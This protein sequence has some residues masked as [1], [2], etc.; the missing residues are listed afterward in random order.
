MKNIFKLLLVGLVFASCD[1]VEPTIYN[2]SSENNTFL[3]FSRTAY[4]LPVER[5]ASGEVVI[6]LNSSTV[7]DVSRTYNIVIDQELSSA[8]PLTYS[9]PQSITIPAGSYQ[10]TAVVSGQDLDLVDAQVKPVYIS[11]SNITNEFVDSNQAIINVGEVCSLGEGVTFTGEYAVTQ[12]TAGFP[13]NS[14]GDPLLNSET[15]VLTEGDSQFV[16]EFTSPIYAAI[17]GPSLTF[18]LSLGCD[19]INLTDDVVSGVACTDT[20][21]GNSITFAPSESPSLYDRAD[22][23]EFFLTVTEEATNACTSPRET[24]IKFTKVQ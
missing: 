10:G 20:P 6:T 12:V 19:A 9:I 21:E 5:D 11:I 7:S 15:V 8:D 2:G 22:D 16:R 14:A 23:S 13:W 3:S 18:T 1:D 24:T 4:F 17:G